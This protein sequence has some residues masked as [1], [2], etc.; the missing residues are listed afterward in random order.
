MYLKRL[1]ISV[2]EKIEICSNARLSS[3]FSLVILPAMSHD[4]HA[5]VHCD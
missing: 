1:T 5:I 3:V 4:G 2:A